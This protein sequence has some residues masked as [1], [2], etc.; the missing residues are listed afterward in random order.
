[1]ASLREWKESPLEQGIDEIVIYTVTVPTSWGQDP[2]TITNTLYRVKP[3][4]TLTD[5]SST[6]LTGSASASGQV[7]TTKAHTGLTLCA[8]NKYMSQVK[9]VVGTKTLE[10]YGIIH[11]RN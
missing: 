3:D 4:G 2:G 5:V 8:T 6:M 10:C 9:F 7:I 11:V 1:M